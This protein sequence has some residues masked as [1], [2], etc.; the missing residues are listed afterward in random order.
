[1]REYKFERLNG[2]KKIIEA[3]SLK[4]AIIK[5]DGKPK[6]HDDHVYITWT[7][8]KKNDSEASVKLPYVT[9]KERKGRI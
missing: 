9:R 3:R 4:K 5:Y 8:K 1:M 2:D 7:N 6:D